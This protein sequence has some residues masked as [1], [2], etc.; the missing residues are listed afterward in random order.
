MDSFLGQ[1]L[2]S[3]LEPKP[4]FFGVCGRLFPLGLCWKRQDSRVGCPC[5]TVVL[6]AGF[7]QLS[8]E[9][10]ALPQAAL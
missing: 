8:S 1:T 4:V 7:R 2:A 5:S 9:I 10:N 6:Q 3:S